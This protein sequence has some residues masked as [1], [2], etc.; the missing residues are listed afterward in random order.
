MYFYSVFG[1]FLRTVTYQLF[2]MILILF[3]YN[4]V[5]K[6]LGAFVFFEIVQTY[7]LSF[8]I[9]LSLFINMVQ[10]HHLDFFLFLK[11]RETLKGFD[12]VSAH[13]EV[14][15]FNN[16]TTTHLCAIIGHSVNTYV[17]KSG[18][19]KGFYNYQNLHLYHIRKILF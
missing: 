16:K 5:R 17:G 6:S 13:L 1:S 10:S 8:F 3:I 12:F 4:H 15:T 9:Y 14:N 19:Q 11:S 7:K 18:A 2:S